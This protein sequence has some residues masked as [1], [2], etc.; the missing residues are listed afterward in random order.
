MLTTTF[1]LLRVRK[2]WLDRQGLD[3]W[4]NPSGPYYDK[5]LSLPCEEGGD[6]Y[7]WLAKQKNWKEPWKTW[8][9]WDK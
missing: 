7:S 3:Q 9:E 6:Y 8:A 4:P 2:W 1:F 5:W